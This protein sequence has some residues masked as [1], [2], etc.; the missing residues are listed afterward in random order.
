MLGYFNFKTRPGPVANNTTLDLAAGNR[1]HDLANLV[2]CS[3]NIYGGNGDA[4]GLE[5]FLYDKT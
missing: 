4:A 2:R 1:T 3:A 5:I